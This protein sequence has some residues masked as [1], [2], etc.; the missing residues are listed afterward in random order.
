MQILQG[1]SS[2]LSKKNT[3]YIL[4]T[5][6]GILSVALLLIN[7]Q[8]FSGDHF[9]YLNYV[10]GF[11]QGRYTYWY[12]LDDYYPD[13]FRNP[14]YPLFLY[15]LSFI[16]PSI[17]LIQVTQLILLLLS[18]YIMLKLIE[19]YDNRL[20]LKNLFLLFVIINFVVLSY[21]PLMYPETLM[22]LLVTL[23][24]Y[25]EICFE[26][27]TWKK[28][29]L[30]V[31]LYGY[32]FQVRPVIIFL[33]FLRV[34]YFLLH[35]KKLS[36]YKNITFLF[37][38]I[39][40]LLPYGF[41]NLQNHHKFQITPLEGGAGAMYLG[42]WSPKMVGYV[43]DRYWRNV[44]H[45]DRFINFVDPKDIP[46][47]ISLFNTEWD[48]V[49]RICNRYLTPRDSANIQVMKMH[50][51]L[52][53]TYNTNY[54][55]QREEMVKALAIRH[56][57]SDWKYTVKLKCYTFFRLWFTGISMKPTF[58]TNLSDSLPIIFAF[59]TGFLSL[60]LF[61]FYFLFC[62]FKRRDIIKTL[63]L[64]LL[65]CLYFDII[66]VPF[67]IQSRYTIPVRFLYLFCVTYMIFNIHFKNRI[68]SENKKH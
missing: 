26:N 66:H 20:E 24:V 55:I 39:L 56:Y 14:G 67:G 15:A 53:I 25:I 48:S 10:K 1:L 11:Q 32:C 27:N 29:L 41:W 18:L 40:T 19:H 45:E 57:M 6:V 51:D 59:T 34:L 12:F 38:F 13:T 30:L 65:L 28:I 62:L 17:I 3:Y 4:L 52:F 7:L 21:S 9:T 5:I 36:L 22:L 37:L 42:Y 33:P 68:Q 58:K 16:T 61:I 23:I 49:E 64:P 44:M 63:L 47:N 54:T 8:D 46:K 35:Y 31:L 60:V 43:E 50:P 2:I